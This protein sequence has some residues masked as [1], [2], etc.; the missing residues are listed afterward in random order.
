MAGVKSRRVRGG[1]ASRLVMAD[2]V[3]AEGVGKC[4]E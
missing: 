2:I 3:G 1:D 4:L